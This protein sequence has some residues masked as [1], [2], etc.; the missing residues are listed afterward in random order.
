MRRSI[1]EPSEVRR[2]AMALRDAVRP[3]FSI[4]AMTRSIMAVYEQARSKSVR[5]TE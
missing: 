5:V 4:E 1:A 2:A 3:V